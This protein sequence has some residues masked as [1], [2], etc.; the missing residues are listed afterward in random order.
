WLSQKR[1]TESADPFGTVLQLSPPP[2]WTHHIGGLDPPSLSAS[3]VPKGSTDSGSRFCESHSDN[4]ATVGASNTT[5]NGTS[6]PSSARIRSTRRI[7]DSECPPR[8]KNES[9]TP[10]RCS[11]STWA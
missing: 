5:R 4:P 2:G 1:E 11:P 10:T 6:S 8:S 3:T 9:S 7:A